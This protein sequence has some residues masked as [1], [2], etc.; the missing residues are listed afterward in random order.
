LVR[1]GQQLYVRKQTSLLLGGVL[2]AAQPQRDR[3]VRL[4]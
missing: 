3:C 2:V 1:P 4:D